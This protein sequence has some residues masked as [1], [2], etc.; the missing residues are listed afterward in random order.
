MKG[1]KY[2]AIAVIFG[3]AVFAVA[4]CQSAS[5]NN[6]TLSNVDAQSY[7][8]TGINLTQDITGSILDWAGSGEVTGLSASSVAEGNYL[9]SATVS[10]EADGWHHLTAATAESGG[11]AVADLHIKLDKVS[12][13][14]VGVWVYGTFSLTLNYT[15]GTTVHTLTFGNGIGDAYHATIARS[16]S[17]IT[18]VGITGVIHYNIAITTA[19]VSHT[20]SMDFNFTDFSAT[21]A[22][23]DDYPTGTIT[24]TNVIRNG[25][26]QPDMTMTFNGTNTVTLTFGDYTGT[27][28]IKPI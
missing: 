18:G 3:L 11:S 21:I 6:N 10:D 2:F 12:G 13:E 24:I 17:T 5:I 16:G 9:S 20:I 22:S 15:K 14:V 1:L 4:G 23:G 27:F 26:A 7:S 28:T 25:A 19:T 8:Q